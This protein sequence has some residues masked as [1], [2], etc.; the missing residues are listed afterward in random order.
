MRSFFKGV[1]RRIGK[2]D[3]E[4]LR[5]QY[6]LIADE[7]D[8]LET[9]FLTNSEGVIVLDQHG[10]A[11]R[12]NPAA[13]TLLGMDVAQALKFLAPRVGE[14]SRREIAISYPEAKTLE[15]RTV[16]FKAGT[17]VYLRDVT[18]EKERTEEELRAGATK[19]VRDLAA[20]V[21]HEIANPL[22]AISLNLQLLERDLPG[23]SSLV[24][25]RQ[26]IARL[27]QILRSFLQALRP[28]KPNL[29]PG[30]IAEPLKNCLAAMKQQF[31]ERRI[32][33]TLD[34]PAALPKV[35][36]DQNQF[37][38]V[39]FNLLKNAIEA[40]GEGGRI[41]IDVLSDDNDDIVTIRDNGEGM[42][43]E[44]LAHLFE[45][46]RT[47]KSK[48]TGLGLMITERIVR[49]HGGSIGAE[50]K[51]GE[52]T[53]FTIRIPRIERRIRALE[54]SQVPSPKS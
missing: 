13:E 7:A 15:M 37:E 46:Y 34:V 47:T 49:D 52:G 32:S 38:Q 26:Q 53:L 28:S 8:F 50:S 2:L 29:L 33:V 31:E 51:P 23:D 21:A 42:S 30:S 43:S 18:A 6:N 9:L 45:P 22:N 12:N 54:Q 40:S 35:T 39:Y 14:A 36:I 41:D 20:G 4:Q 10:I 48:G 44:Q 19:A 3:A 24:I 5:E 11:L 16:P 25:C 1:R 17:I 27:E